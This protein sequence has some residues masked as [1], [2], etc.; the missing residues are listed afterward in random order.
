M[1]LGKGVQVTNTHIPSLSLS[2]AISRARA[3]VSSTAQIAPIESTSAA[4]LTKWQGQT[5][6]ENASRITALN[7]TGPFQRRA[8]LPLPR[9]LATLPDG[10]TVRAGRTLSKGAAKLWATLHRLALSVA[11]ERRYEVVPGRVV[12]HLTAGAL[13]LKLGYTERHLSRLSAELEDAGL[14]QAGAYAQRVGFQAMYDG[15]L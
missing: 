15:C 3:A 6:A 4:L 5:H 9:L 14:I 8:V 10:A 12:F 1:R 2:E 13:A 7:L 11:R